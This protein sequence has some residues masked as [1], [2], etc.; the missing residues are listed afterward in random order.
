M[1]KIRIPNLAA[2][3]AWVKRKKRREGKL[4]ETVKALAQFA[5]WAL[6]NGPFDG[7]GL[8]G[9]DVQEKAAKLGLIVPDPDEPNE[10]MLSTGLS[11]ILKTI[12]KK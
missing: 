11:L 3:I 6:V 5:R 4:V 9:G 7:C 10:W 1:P 8:D 12:E 2:R